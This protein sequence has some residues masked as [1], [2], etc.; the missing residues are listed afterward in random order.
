M[1]HQEKVVIVVIKRF[2]MKSLVKLS[3]KPQ[4]KVFLEKPQGYVLDIGGGGEGAI[5][6]TCGSE[7]VCVDI[8]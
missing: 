3:R 1:K 4:A 7:I 6:K 2:L 8:S 5:A